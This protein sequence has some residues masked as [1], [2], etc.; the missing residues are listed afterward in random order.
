MNT[1]YH[2]TS[3]KRAKKALRRGLHS[4]YLTTDKWVRGFFAQKASDEDGSRPVYLKVVVRDTS[5]L[6][7]DE[8]M[9]EEPLSSIIK[10]YT[11]EE[12]YRMIEVGLKPY[13]EDEFDWKTSLKV[14]KSVWYAG[15]IRPEDILEVVEY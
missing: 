9:Y 4:P 15:T 14:V 13:P 7:P 2:G 10:N 6:R 3:E 12:W 1:L 5:K 8:E 11:L